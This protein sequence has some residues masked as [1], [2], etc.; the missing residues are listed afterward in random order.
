MWTTYS[1][2]IAKEFLIAIICFLGLFAGLVIGYFSRSEL[3]DGRKFFVWIQKFVF[4]AVVFLLF[5][6]MGLWLAGLAFTIFFSTVLYLLKKDYSRLKY[7]ALAVFL[8]LSFFENSIIIPLLVFF[9]GFPT[10]SIFLQ[11]NE[12]KYFWLVC[13]QLFE[14]YNFFLLI[15]ALLL[16]VKFVIGV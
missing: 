6:E 12:K 13:L 8:F 16:A 9:Y 7:F 1:A 11:D 15:V 2:I 10:G 14:K 3:K 4:V 5:F